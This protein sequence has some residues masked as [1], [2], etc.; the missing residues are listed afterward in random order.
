MSVAFALCTEACSS[1]YQPARSPRIS[2]IQEGGTPTLVRD[3]QKFPV[4]LFG[5]GLEDAVTGN[6]E[7][8]EHAHAYRNFTIGGWT[9]SV[10]ALG[11]AIGGLVLLGDRSFHEEHG[12]A[13]P[14]TLLV[15]ALVAD[16]AAA[17]L[18]ANAPPHMADAINVYN[19]GVDAAL[20]R[21]PPPWS[22][23]PPPM[24][25]PGAPLPSSNSSGPPIP[26]SA[27]APTFGPPN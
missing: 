12:D 7:A 9:C 14:A 18:L 21:T 10:A 22:L 25:P 17:I 5:G 19:D 27:P 13:L 16:I 15:S 2:V 23:P 3:G 4:G 11:S 1:S 8:E 20:V 6:Q 24:V 26:P